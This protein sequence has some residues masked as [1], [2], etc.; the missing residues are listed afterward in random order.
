MTAYLPM[1]FCMAIIAVLLLQADADAMAAWLGT[2]VKPRR[3]HRDA[4]AGVC[5]GLALWC[6]YA[7]VTMLGAHL[8]AVKP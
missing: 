5:I 1:A 2:R 7:A 4:F 3:W 8:E 6:L